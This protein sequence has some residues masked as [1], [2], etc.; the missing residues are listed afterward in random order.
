MAEETPIADVSANT[1]TY[2]G[3]SY[4]IRPLSDDAFTVLHEG[5]PVGRIVYSFGAANGV[6]EG[7]AIS[8]EALDA[9]AEVWFAATSG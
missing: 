4:T 5:V 2:A 9:I 1:V 8:G 7:D 6:V 3:K